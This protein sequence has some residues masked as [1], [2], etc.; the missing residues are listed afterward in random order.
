MP[1]TAYTMLVGCLAIAGAGLPFTISIAGQDLG[2]GL[3]GYFSKDAI[4]E[5]ALS[6]RRENSGWGTV[7]FVVA[8]GGAAITAFYMFRLWYLTFA[9]QPRNR[10]RYDHAH[11][12]PPVMYR[13]L[14]LLAVLAVAVAWGPLHA[15]VGAIVALILFAVLKFRSRLP[16]A[17]APTHSSPG[18][19]DSGHGQP[20]VHEHSTEAEHAHSSH[21]HVAVADPL[22]AAM[23]LALLM[24][25]V[26]VIWLPFPHLTLANLLEQARPAGTLDTQQA[27]FCSLVW[28]NEHNSHAPEIKV[29][30]TWIAF[31]TA[32]G[33]FVLSTMFYG[34]RKLDPAEAQRTFAPVYRLLIHKWWFDELYDY[35]FVRPVHV[36]AQLAARLDRSVIDGLIDGLASGVRV[37]ADYWDQ[38][39]DRGLVDGF[40]NRFASVTYATGLGLRRAQT[41]SLRQYVMFIVIGTV[42][43]V[44][45]ASI[46]RHAMAF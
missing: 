3:S 37:F 43:I 21:G 46:W 27:V 10:Q 45:I 5:Q 34:L 4:L 26:G 36:V 39:A 7:F 24:L 44:A 17:P 15:I 1:W 33:G 8:A 41:G 9:G 30:A 25:L 14:I 19:S 12:S 13:P 22:N 31:A 16:V 11:E 18:Q 42:V 28:P 6:F 23:G 35:L 2:I 38:I 20:H 40:V 32:L 29:P